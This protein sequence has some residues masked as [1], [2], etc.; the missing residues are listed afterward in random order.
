MAV[1]L[2]EAP[3]GQLELRADGPPDATVIVHT[4]DGQHVQQGVGR[5]GVIMAATAFYDPALQQGPFVAECEGA[6]VFGLGMKAFTNHDH[7]NVTFTRRA[8]VGGGS[9]GADEIINGH[10]VRF[11]FLDAFHA[12]PQGLGPPISDQIFASEGGGGAGTLTL[13]IFRNAV[14]VWDGAK[15]VRVRKA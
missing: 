14:L 8:P 1:A 6:R 13:Q 7:P 2:A 4:A 5:A 10:A 3:P 12:D 11:G 15:V 9:N